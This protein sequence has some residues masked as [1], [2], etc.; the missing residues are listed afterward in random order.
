MPRILLSNDD[1][2]QAPG[3]AALEKALQG[4]GELWVVAP[5]EP[6]SAKSH[7][8]T[9]HKSVKISQHGTRRF[10]VR[11]TPVDSVYAGI[12]RLLPGPPDLVVSGINRGANIGEDVHYS[13]TVGAAREAVLQGYP[14]IAVSLHVDF[15]HPIE[16]HNWK[17]AG[18]QVRRLAEEV[19]QRGLAPNCL[20]NLNVPDVPP[21]AC[22]GIKA[23]ALGHHFYAPLVEERPDPRGDGFFKLGGP[24][25][26]FGP[27]QSSEGHL[28]ESGWASL[29]PLT[30]RVTDHAVLNDLVGWL[31]VDSFHSE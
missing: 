13:G 8:L 12:H 10:A 17:T 31:A 29:S 21:A 16:S 1:G 27:Q 30:V 4:L 6:Q 28:V 25:M 26:D 22:K 18:E 20:L 5:A 24:H 23:C 19:I 11:G 14:A 9:L 2:I 15:A 3:L 7:A